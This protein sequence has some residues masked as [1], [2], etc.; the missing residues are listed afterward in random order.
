[1]AIDMR[2]LEKV[3]E[4]SYALYAVLDN[5]PEADLNKLTLQGMNFK[6]RKSLK[7]KL[8]QLNLACARANKGEAPPKR[9]PIYHRPRPAGGASSR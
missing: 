3:L 4:L 8:H 9:A 5:I 6:V 1:M 2:P 7:W